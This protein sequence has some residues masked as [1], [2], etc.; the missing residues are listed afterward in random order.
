MSSNSNR[1]L[2]CQI[3]S[4]KKEMEI[5]IPN[6]GLVTLPAN[7]FMLVLDEHDRVQCLRS[8]EF[9]T[10]RFSRQFIKD[11]IGFLQKNPDYYHADTYTGPEYII[12]ES[13]YVDLLMDM[14]ACSKDKIN[15]DINYEHNRLVIFS[16]LSLFINDENFIPLLKCAIKNTITMQVYHII[17]QDIC[18]PWRVDIIAKHLSLST[19]LLKSRLKQEGSSYI[20]IVTDCRMHYAVEQMSDMSKSIADIAAICGYKSRDYFILVFRKHFGVTPLRYMLNRQKIPSL[21]G[22]ENARQY[23]LNVRQGRKME[24]NIKFG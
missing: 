24:M 19:S 12:A 11:Y 9:N 23:N 7:H 2:C 3:I 10:I 20:K 1:N 16:L 14:S 6:V 17:K 13:Q 21:A 22:A 15:V 8:N 5:A 4:A 18:Y